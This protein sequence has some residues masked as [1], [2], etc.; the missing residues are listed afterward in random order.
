MKNK[1]LEVTKFPT[2]KLTLAE[3]KIPTDPS[4][5]FTFTGTMNLHGINRLIEGEA[6]LISNGSDDLLSA[7]FK[8]KL[9]DFQI[10]LPSFQGITV[11]EDVLVNI[12]APL[13]KAE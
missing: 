13:T 7:H 4:H 1:Y 10:E 12:E 6:Q 9:S 11:A 8:I 2:A 5:N 3:L